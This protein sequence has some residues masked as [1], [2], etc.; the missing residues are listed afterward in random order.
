MFHVLTKD[1]L[2]K[3]E[4]MKLSFKCTIRMDDIN[5]MIQQ[6]SATHEKNFFFA[7]EKKYLEFNLKHMWN[8]TRDCFFQKKIR[9]L[10]ENG[11]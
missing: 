11:K 8:T 7:Y 6:T 10:S 3:P 1:R 9:K 5:H 2:F 4:E